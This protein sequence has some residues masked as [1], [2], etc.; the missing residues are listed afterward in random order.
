MDEI[1][2]GLVLS[3]VDFIWVLRP[4]SVSHNDPNVLPNGFEEEIKN[5]GLV[6]SWCNQIEILA[7]PAVGGFMTHCGWNSILESLLYG[8]PLLCF[9]QL[10]DQPTNRKIVVDDWRT[11]VNLCD[12]KPLTRLEVAEKIKRLMSGKSDEGLREETMKVRQ[13]LKKAL[14]TEGSS[15]KNLIQF[16]SDVKAKISKRMLI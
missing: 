2:Y 15:E 9:P 6:V 10:A 12:R 14:D 1:A 5:R 11:G 16:M 13:T 8:V 4:E 7:N 3:Q